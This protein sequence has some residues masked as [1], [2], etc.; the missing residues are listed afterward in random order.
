MFIVGLEIIGLMGV[1]FF[2]FKYK[3]NPENS[4]KKVTL[5][6]MTFTLHGTLN[7]DNLVVKQF[8]NGGHFENALVQWIFDISNNL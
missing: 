6:G 8:L 3:D 5:F 2:L 7:R 1:F 4:E